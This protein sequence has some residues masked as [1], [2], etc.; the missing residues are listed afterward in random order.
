MKSA[1]QGHRDLE[2]WQ[3]AME[4]VM[5]IYTATQRFPKDEMYGLT[6]QLRRAAVSIPSNIAEGYGR[7]SRRELR[8]FIG[9]A[10]GS[11]LELETQVEIARD[12]GYFAPQV[13]T[14][15][16]QETL[17]LTQL[18]NGLRSWAEKQIEAEN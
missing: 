15:L 18:L 17:R 13:A 2:C 8:K 12:L 1:L 10:I 4:V 7:K 9:N 3:V 11:L 16:L 5:D 6:S 14:D